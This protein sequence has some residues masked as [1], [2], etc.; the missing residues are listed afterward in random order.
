MEEGETIEEALG[1][2]VEE[3]L[4]LRVKDKE[5]IFQIENDYGEEYHYLVRKYEGELKLG[6]PEAEASNERNQYI[7]TWVSKAE[8]EGLK[9]F[10]PKASRLKILAEWD[11]MAS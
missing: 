2:E 3:E 7:L 6:G 8:F 9:V 10:Y 4:S 1:R 5:F 11:I